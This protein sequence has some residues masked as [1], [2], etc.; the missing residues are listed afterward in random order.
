MAPVLWLSLWAAVSLALD[1]RAMLLPDFRST[2]G[3][4]VQLITEPRF[5]SHLGV[6]FLRII[7]GALLS[8][9]CGIPVGLWLASSRWARQLVEPLVDFL[10]GVPAA[11]LFPVAIIL[12]GVGEAAR[13]FLTSY[14]SLPIVVTA[15]LVGAAE[16]PENSGR[17][18][19]IRLHRRRVSRWHPLICLLWDAAPSVLG[20]L[21]ISLS[22]SLVVVIVTE[23]FFIGGAGVGWYAWE[24]YQAS[25]FPRMY[26][27][28]LIIGIMSLAM[29]YAIDVASTV[30]ARR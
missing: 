17:R 20:G 18:S 29:N 2:V 21:K 25:E 3:A 19:Y 4:A 6:T 1:L 8:I 7:P 10:R 24:Q 23:M 30:F 27:I 5:L 11:T 26:A 14:V 28:L 9:A 15:T 16:S 13:V 22:L 12:F